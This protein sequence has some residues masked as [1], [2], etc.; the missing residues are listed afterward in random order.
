[1]PY[2]G[3]YGGYGDFLA[4]NI[5]CI[6]LIPILILSVWA[7]AQVS[8]N[9]KRYSGVA[10][11]RRLTGAQAAEAVLRAH[12]VYNVAIRP[13]AG[14][15]TDHYDPRDNSISLSENVYNSASIA[16]V[17]VAAHEAGHAVQY[18]EGYAPLKFRNAI[19]PVTQ[20]GAKLSTPLVI[21]GLILSIYPLAYAGIIL[22][23]AVVV[24]QLVTL[25]T[26]FNASRRALAVLEEGNYLDG[27]E[28]RGAKKVLSAAAMTYVAALFMSLMSL[29]RLIVIV[30]GSKNSRNRR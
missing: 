8:G 22:F 12:G 30:S 26:E 6:L 27:E 23:G 11:R 14:N 9:F 3:Y 19:V 25:P 28:L 13:C 7:Q 20:F 18:A 17:G 21:L 24:F 5:Y 15:L 10:N 29:L 1:M 16:A 4:N 2:Y